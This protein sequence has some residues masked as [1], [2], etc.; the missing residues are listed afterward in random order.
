[1]LCYIDSESLI[2]DLLNIE[3]DEDILN[4]QYV[5]VS[6]YI[7]TRTTPDNIMTCSVLYPEPEIVGCIN[8]NDRKDFYMRQLEHSGKAILA[9]LILYDIQN[10]G[11]I[12][13]VCNK[14]ELKHVKYL[15]WLGE[16]VINTFKYPMYYYKDYVNG[17]DIIDYDE[18]SV[19]K[20]CFDILDRE[21]K[22]ARIEVTTDPHSRIKYL[23]N[24][25]HDKK[26]L[27]KLAKRYHLYNK[28]MS[29]SELYEAL[30]D[31]FT[32]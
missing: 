3:D 31:E 11:S 10:E 17:C 32:L 1:M 19:A 21:K 22:K 18:Y 7:S 15:K 12:I 24:I 6:N 23:G 27:K 5:L 13:F 28:G 29:R 25:K 30:R 9:T 8:K 20:F 16:Y 14:S 2:D 26:A 4:F